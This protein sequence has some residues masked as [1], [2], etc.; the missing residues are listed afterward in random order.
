MKILYVNLLF[1]ASL[2]FLGSVTIPPSHGIPVDKR[3]LMNSDSW[4]FRFNTTDHLLIGWPED[5]S[6]IRLLDYLRDHRSRDFS[7]LNWLSAAS[8]IAMIFSFIGWR[9][10]RK[11]QKAA[12]QGAAANP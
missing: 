3:L 11:L 1:I 8:V 10:E 4:T 9:R 6:K 12:E 7:P 2:V 5:Q